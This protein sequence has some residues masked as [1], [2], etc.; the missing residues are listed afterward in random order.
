MKRGYVVEKSRPYPTGNV[1]DRFILTQVYT[2]LNVP[3]QAAR[4]QYLDRDVLLTFCTWL[5]P[6]TPIVSRLKPIRLL[7]SYPKQHAG[8]VKICNFVTGKTYVP[9]SLHCS[10]IMQH[11]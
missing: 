10:N 9:A 2:T 7:R 11:L 6:P 5:G 1:P 4:I 3:L 8:L